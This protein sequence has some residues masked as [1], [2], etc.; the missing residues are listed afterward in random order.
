MKKYLPILYMLVAFV[1]L[2]RLL[3]A[4]VPRQYRATPD[5]ARYHT[6]A[7]SRKMHRLGELAPGVELL[8]LGDSRAAYGVDP[9]FFSQRPDA[10]Q[11]RAFNLAPA[12]GGIPFTRQVLAENLDRLPALRTVVWGVSPRIFN[13]F[14]N[15][16]IADLYANSRGF[17]FERILR[18]TAPEDISPAGLKASAGV[19]FELLFSE[20][21][22]VF[23]HRAV[24]KSIL[25]DRVLP[26]ETPRFVTDDVT[27]LSPFGY[28]AMPHR[29]YVNTA[30]PVEV[31]KYRRAHRR[32]AFRKDEKRMAEFREIIARLRAR[33][34]KLALFIPPMHFSLTETPVADHDGTPR[35]EYRDLVKQLG[36][37][38]KEF[39]NVLFL[40][41]NN[42]GRNDFKDEHWANYDHLTP[43]GAEV[44]T[45][46]LSAWLGPKGVLPAGHA[47][48]AGPGAQASREGSEGSERARTLALALWDEFK[49]AFFADLEAA[50]V[51]KTPPVARHN[52]QG[53]Y[54]VVDM[55]REPFPLFQVNYSDAQ[56]GIDTASVKI[57]LNDEDVTAGAQVTGAAVIYKPKTKLETGL[58]SVRVIVKDKAGNQTEISWDVMYQEC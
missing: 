47:L 44:L 30:D 2:D 28:M 56:S 15:D 22:R 41:T 10:N 52:R 54:S 37:L 43:G 58:Y 7:F 19:A 1:I 23:A 48:Q 38:P 49:R 24:I 36:A 4:E 46:R 14:W 18:K 53:D 6:E 27:E 45:R 17:Q 57:F 21:S 39:D 40:D 32:G 3:G 5:F 33:G 16:P 34:V 31:A 42:A 13:A 12:S 35:E 9:A 25:L 50:P 11:V 8:V 29:R 20:A 51:D 26:R 55:A